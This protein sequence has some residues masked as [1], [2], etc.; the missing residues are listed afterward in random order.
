M[1]LATRELHLA[2]LLGGTVAHE[3]KT[4]LLTIRN[5]AQGS[6]SGQINNSLNKAFS[7][8]N[9]LLTNIQGPHKPLKLTKLSIKD[10]LEYS[11]NAYPIDENQKNIINLS[12]DNDFYFSGDKEMIAHVI[13]NLIN[14]SLYY[15]PN[16]KDLSI[17]ITSRCDSKYNYLIFRDNG[18]GMSPKLIARIFDKFYTESK[19]GSGLGLS[20]CKLTMQLIG[21]DIVCDSIEEQYTEFVLQF[22]KFIN[23]LSG[24]N[25]Y[26]L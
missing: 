15:T 2:K 25:R 20:F 7:F 16:R 22:P 17:D 11:I 21:G 3:L 4:Y 12:I 10:C 26:I 8:I 19:K 24:N 6:H 14:N 18:P 9:T 23:K 5:Y 1:E 13:F